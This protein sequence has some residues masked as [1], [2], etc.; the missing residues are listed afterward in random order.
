M[1]IIISD[2]KATCA[3]CYFKCPFALCI[4]NGFKCE[5]FYPRDLEQFLKIE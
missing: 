5:Y 3:Y 4:K 1:N 2:S